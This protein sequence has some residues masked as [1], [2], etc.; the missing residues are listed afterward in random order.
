M[1]RVV[2][3]YYTVRDLCCLLRYS[4]TWVK[5]R[6]KAGDF[7]DGVLDVSGDYRVPAS[8][9]NAFLDRYK[10]TGAIPVG[11]A[12]RTQ[13][14]LLRKMR[15]NGPVERHPADVGRFKPDPAP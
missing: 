9:V 3:L 4:D 7:G 5:Q 8:G 2:E 15:R 10:F 13:G 14:E 12:A 6:I 1:T 11:T